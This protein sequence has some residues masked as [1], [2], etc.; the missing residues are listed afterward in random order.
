MVFDDDPLVCSF[1]CM[2][3]RR[4]GH[5]VTA[6]SDPVFCPL[7]ESESC[8][9]PVGKPCADIILTDLEM[10][11]IHGLDF[12]E[13]QLKK[14]CKCRHIALISGAWSQSNLSRAKQLRVKVMAKPVYAKDINDWLD[15][16]EKDSGCCP[17]QR[18]G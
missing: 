13:G 9:H 3:L 1:L 6:F 5:E 15:E 12:V 7:T 10:P 16:V 17:N 2:I 11:H 14:G 8:P 18:T 4:R